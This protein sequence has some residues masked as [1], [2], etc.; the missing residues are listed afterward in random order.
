MQKDDVVVEI[1]G[2]TQRLS[3]SRLLGH[4]LQKRFPGERVPLVLLRGGEK[5][6]LELPMQ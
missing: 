4:L 2:L 3:E 1:D 6:S 5:R